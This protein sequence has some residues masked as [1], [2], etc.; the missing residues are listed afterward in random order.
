[1]RAAALELD[2]V[3][4]TEEY[5]IDNPMVRMFAGVLGCDHTPPV[6]ENTL[7]AARIALRQFRV[8]GT[9]IADANQILE[10][11]GIDERIVIKPRTS[12]S[13]SLTDDQRTRL[14]EMNQY[15]LSL[16]AMAVEGSL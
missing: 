10:C 7:L 1:M 14:V 12:T 2:V 8:V 6:D 15:D 3:A 4:F 5:R 13:I 9:S 11:L 16:W